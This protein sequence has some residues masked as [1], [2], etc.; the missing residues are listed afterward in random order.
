MEFKNGMVL[1]AQELN[2]I[3][4]AINDLVTGTQDDN[5][6]KDKITNLKN[7]W[8]NILAKANNST[9]NILTITEQILSRYTLFTGKKYK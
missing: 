2:E 8:D 1:S 7:A 4:E 6:I 5:P 9:D 3:T